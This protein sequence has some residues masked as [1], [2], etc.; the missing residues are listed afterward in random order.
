MIPK[1]SRL[2]SWSSSRNSCA[3]A[4]QCAASLRDMRDPIQIV[5]DCPSLSSAAVLPR[6]LVAAAA[7]DF[8]LLPL[9]VEVPGR[10][11]GTHRPG[12][13][14]LRSLRVAS[15]AEEMAAAALGS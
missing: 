1:F 8:A 7:Q 13:S 3:T 6:V 12:A 10:A 14:A 9:A 5:P 15:K 11:C 2:H 4:A